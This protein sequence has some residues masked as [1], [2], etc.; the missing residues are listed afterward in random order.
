M[1]HPYPTSRELRAEAAAERL[2][3]EQ[4]QAEAA[5]RRVV[6]AAR[7]AI[8]KLEFPLAGP[9]YRYEPADVL[10][11]LDELMVGPEVD[12]LDKLATDMARDAMA[13]AV[14]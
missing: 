1:N 14:W 10:S 5:F 11:L 4:A 12:Y 9:S 13:E 3:A 6:N 7:A 8:G 2:L